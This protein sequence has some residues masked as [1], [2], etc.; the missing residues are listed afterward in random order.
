[1]YNILI[2]YS[3]DEIKFQKRDIFKKGWIFKIKGD[4]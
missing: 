4:P 3:F 2:T 1:M